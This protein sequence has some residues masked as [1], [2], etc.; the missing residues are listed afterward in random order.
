MFALPSEGSH[1]FV[2]GVLGELEGTFPKVPSNNPASNPR[3]KQKGGFFF[4]NCIKSVN[5]CYII[6]EYLEIDIFI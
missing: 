1:I 6:F 2:W 4:V 5:F 3:P